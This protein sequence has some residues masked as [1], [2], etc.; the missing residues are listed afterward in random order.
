M[1]DEILRLLNGEKISSVPAFSGLIHVTA[2]GLASEELT[3]R[4]VH[5][6]AGKMARAAASTFKLTGMP[7]AALPLDLCSPA[8]A[9]GSELIFYDN[10]EMQFPQVKKLLFQSTRE[11]LEIEELEIGG[12]IGLICDAISLLKKDI[13]NRAVI[14]GMIPGPYTL[15]IYICKVQ[16]LVREMKNEPQMVLDAL[17]R[18][19]S[20]L[21]EIGKAYLDAGAD[22]ITIHEMGGSPGF[23]G[24]KPFE[25]FVLPAL[26][27]LTSSLPHPTVLSVCGKTDSAMS[28]LAQAGADAISVDQLND[29]NA[30]RAVLK[31][32]LLFGNVDP[33]A[34]LW[35][36]SEGSVPEAVQRSKE[37]GVNA[38]WP[39]CDM[40][41]QTPV[42]NIHA[43]LG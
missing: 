17:L 33:V 40:V 13:G 12:R 23:I 1:R 21:A 2:E 14:S 10:D 36:G 35:Q 15:M 16:N 8:E 27:K 28:L 38:V 39:G 34:V 6:D 9:L 19:S 24:P 3:L 4:E 7:S 37:A 32:T 29:L 20:F 18:L 41:I 31:E 42:Q 5:H 25:S 22:F 43:M 11:I 30:S 26:Q